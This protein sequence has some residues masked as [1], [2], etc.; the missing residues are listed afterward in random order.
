MP[1]YQKPAHDRTH[2]YA[3][4]DGDPINYV[5]P[6]GL[7]GIAECFLRGAAAGAVGAAVID[8]AALAAA[9]VGVPVVAVTVGIAATAAVGAV[10]LGGSISVN[11][12]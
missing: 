5:D 2:F 3:Y 6:S 11:V 10:V 4:V 8:A 7:N 1:S 12:A 9:A